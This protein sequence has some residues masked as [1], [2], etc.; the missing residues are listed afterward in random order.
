MKTQMYLKYQQQHVLQHIRPAA[1]HGIRGESPD[2][3]A[4]CTRYQQLLA[5]GPIHVTCAGIGEN[6]HLAF[7][8]PPADFNDPVSVKIVNLGIWSLGFLPCVLKHGVPPKFFHPR[9]VALI[10]SIVGFDFR[11]LA[12]L[13]QAI[14]LVGCAKGMNPAKQRNTRR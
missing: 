4:E 7:N 1:F 6:G 3:V 2:P 9:I 13:I 12:L 11:H 10:G 8:D 5:E 14:S